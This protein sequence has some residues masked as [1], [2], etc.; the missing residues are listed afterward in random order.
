MSNAVIWH[1]VECGAYTAD[2]WLWRELAEQGSGPVLELGAGTGRVALDLAGRGY[3]VTALDS[4]PALLQELGR[5]AAALRVDVSRVNAD[6][7]SLPPLG[8]FALVLAPMQFVQI[9]GGASARG[10]LLRGVAGLLAEGGRFAAALAELE[11]ALAPEDA[12]PPLPD[13]V[14]R[15][16]W[17]YSSLPMDVRR[18]PAGV[19]VERLRQ[20]VSPS[21]QLSDERHTQL[22]DSVSPEALEAEARA[23]GLTPEARHTV[24]GTGEHV[25]STVIVCRR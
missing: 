4:D 5:R 8:V 13:L 2:L 23:C 18:D 19:A 7:R 16:G 24:R 12:A 25:G 6:A 9:M 14:E 21:G 10:E 15:D 3:E 1:D 17:V 20:I 11:H 22:L